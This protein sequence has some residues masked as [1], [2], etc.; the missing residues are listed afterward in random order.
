MSEAERILSLSIIS[1][2]INLKQLSLVSKQPIPLPWLLHQELTRLRS[3]QASDQ[4]KPEF[5][6]QGFL[7]LPGASDEGLRLVNPIFSFRGIFTLQHSKENSTM[8]NC[9]LCLQ[10]WFYS[11]HSFQHH[12][13]LGSF[14]TRGRS[15]CTAFLCAAPTPRLRRADSPAGNAELSVQGLSRHLSLF[16]SMGVKNPH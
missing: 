1:Q 4:D 9:K 16:V 12:V 8:N 11:H 6:L 3:A 7:Q 10:Q 14:P 2:S 13:L 15:L 5:H